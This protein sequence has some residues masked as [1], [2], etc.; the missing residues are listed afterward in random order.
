MPNRGTYQFDVQANGSIIYNVKNLELT[1]KLFRDGNIISGNW[2]PG[3]SG[4]FDY[5]GW[6]C[7]CHL[8]AGAG[9]F[10]SSNGYLW[11]AITHA[12]N[13]DK[14]IATISSKKSDGTILTVGLSSTEG[15]DFLNQANLVGYVE[16]TS[17]GHISARNVQDPPGAFNSWPRQA[18]DHPPDSNQQGGTVWEHWSTTRDLRE[19][20]VIGDSVL[21][22][23]LSLV[24]TLGGQFVATIARGRRTYNHPVQL[25]ALV[26]A[27]FIARDDALWD[28]MPHRIPPQEE[29]LLNEARPADSLKAVESLE[30]SLSDGRRY[31]MFSRRISSWSIK[32]NVESDLNQFI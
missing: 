22:A 3:R 4:D 29:H 2:G 16:G 21:R 18:F 28:S 20:S 1:R 5:G 14:Y 12:G 7:L 19:T 9:V 31:F 10:Q 11:V 27:G 13:E 24:S 25:C 26:K 23:Y 8:A 32:S 6:H 17:V 15:Q 30:W